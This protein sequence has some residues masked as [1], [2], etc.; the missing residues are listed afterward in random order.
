MV[1]GE[2]ERATRVVLDRFE[3]TEELDALDVTIADLRGT[4]GL[5]VFP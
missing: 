1:T 2:Q 4:P 3:Q 5:E